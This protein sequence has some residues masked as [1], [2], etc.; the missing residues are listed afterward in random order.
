MEDEI[1]VDFTEV[2]LVA[3]ISQKADRILPTHIWGNVAQEE[4]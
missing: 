4:R 1:G 3:N 2:A